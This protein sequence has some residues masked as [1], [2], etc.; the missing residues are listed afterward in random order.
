MGKQGI[1]APADKVVGED[2]TFR[3]KC[4]PTEMTRPS[5]ARQM[6]LFLL[7]NGIWQARLRTGAFRRGDLVLSSCSFK[8]DF[9][10][11]LLACVFDMPEQTTK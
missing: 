4:I 1:G 10:L 6:A 8:A 9:I 11:R 5:A 3:K 7:E 2:V